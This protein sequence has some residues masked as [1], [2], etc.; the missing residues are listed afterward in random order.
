MCVLKTQNHD[1]ENT[2]HWGLAQCQKMAFQ[3]L[4]GKSI[5]FICLIKTVFFYENQ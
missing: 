5:L 4:C 1:L 2:F 3:F